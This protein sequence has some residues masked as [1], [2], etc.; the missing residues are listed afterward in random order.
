LRAHINLWS[1][2]HGTRVDIS[3]LK[4]AE[5]RLLKSIEGRMK[6][7]MV[8]NG[9]NRNLKLNMLEDGQTNNRMMWY[10]RF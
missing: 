5:M 10:G 1:T 2:N 4:I 6:R 9:K 3:R 7:D 8:R